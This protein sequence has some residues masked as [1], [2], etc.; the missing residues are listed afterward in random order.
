MLPSIYIISLIVFSGVIFVLVGIL[1]LVESRLT[2]K[3]LRR[4]LIN[5]DEDKSV[6]A[7][8]G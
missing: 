8:G 2:V 5:D 4:V 6:D 3:G 7:S 1:L